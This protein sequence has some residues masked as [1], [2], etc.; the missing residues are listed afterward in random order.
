MCFLL[1]LSDHCEPRQLR[2]G[3]VSPA[4]GMGETKG[5]VGYREER[6]GLV[7]KDKTV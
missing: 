2:H 5:N 6:S 1:G 3:N 4:G 7:E